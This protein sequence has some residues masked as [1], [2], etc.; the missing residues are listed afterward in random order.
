MLVLIV[1]LTSGHPLGVQLHQALAPMTEP[2]LVLGI[3]ASGLMCLIRG[4]RGSRQGSYYQDNRRGRS[5]DRW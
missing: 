3:L 4:F 5:Y 2:L 1:L